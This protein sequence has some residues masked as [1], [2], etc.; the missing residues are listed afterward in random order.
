MP[1]VNEWKV[2]LDQHTADLHHHTVNLRWS[3]FDQEFH[4]GQN[5][6]T[7]PFVVFF[8]QLFIFKW[9]SSRI[10]RL[11]K[12]SSD[13]SFEKLQ[14]FNNNGW[15]LFLYIPFSELC[16]QF[17]VQNFIIFLCQMLCVVNHAVQ[18]VQINW[19]IVEAAQTFQNLQ[20]P[21]KLIKW[22]VLRVTEED[23]HEIGKYVNVI[24]VLKFSIESHLT[25]FNR[26]ILDEFRSEISLRLWDN[27]LVW[28]DLNV[29]K[30]FAR[31]HIVLT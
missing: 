16:H 19:F 17:C 13:I 15:L 31:S 22:Q 9:F 12:F 5:C 24:L 3:V 2:K 4:I 21:F 10:K 11:L 18:Y 7:D 8:C 1:E 27:A 6:L 29:H 28:I 23:T 30:M 25:K 14:K 20:Y 26:L